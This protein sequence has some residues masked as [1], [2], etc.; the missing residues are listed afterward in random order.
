MPFGL[1]NIGAK[2]QRLMNNIFE[3]QKGINVKVYVDNVLV[4]SF[5]VESLI[6][7]IVETFDT[8]RRYDL[9]LNLEKC[10]FGIRSGRF[11]GYIATDRGIRV[12]PTK[13]QTLQNMKIPPWKDYCFISFYI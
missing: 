1:K 9:K 13:I 7:D 11:L 10:I 5:S 8:L 6:R 2:Y 4:K 3:K 12:N